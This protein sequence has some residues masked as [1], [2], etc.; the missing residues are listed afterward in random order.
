MSDTWEGMLP[1]VVVD[2]WVE[3]W[4]SSGW[5]DRP[6]PCAETYERARRPGGEE[7]RG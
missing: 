7:E 5:A 2:E 6:T 3:Q 1:V 4:R